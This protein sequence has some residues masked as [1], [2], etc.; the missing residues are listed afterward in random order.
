[1]VLQQIAGSHEAGVYPIPG[2]SCP[3]QTKKKKKKIMKFVKS[4]FKLIIKL[5]NF[6]T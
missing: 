4:K 3:P 2:S 6:Q 1:M 5:V